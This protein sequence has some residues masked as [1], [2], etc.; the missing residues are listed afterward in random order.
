[1]S[2]TNQNMV[3]RRIVICALYI[4]MKSQPMIMLTYRVPQKHSNTSGMNC[5]VP[6]RGLIAAG[7]RRKEVHTVLCALYS[8]V[9]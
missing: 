1:M 2:P 9:K 3:P 7:Q 5:S 8:D 4:L 6:F